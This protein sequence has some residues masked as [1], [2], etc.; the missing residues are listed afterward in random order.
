MDGGV[1]ATTGT[2]LGRYRL[3]QRIGEG[4]MGVVHLG[5][6]DDGRAFA[7]KVLRPHVAG[8]ADARQR[9]AREVSTLRRVR[10]RRIAEVVDADTDCET[11][12]VV[13]Q[14]VPGQPLDAHVREHGPVTGRSL[15]QLGDGLGEALAAIHAAGIVHRDLK[16]GNVLMLDGDPVVIDFGIAHVADDVRLTSTGLVMG[17][18]GYLSPE[19]VAGDDV[20][21]ATDWWG[22]AATMAF[23]ATGRPPFGR[24][25][26]EA[27]LDRVRRGSADLEGVPAALVPVLV[28]ALSVDPRGRPAPGVLR[29][30]VADLRA[31]AVARVDGAREE[32]VTERI[33]VPP[34]PGGVPPRPDVAHELRDRHGAE[35]S[36]SAL[37]AP[38]TRALPRAEPRRPEHVAARGVPARPAPVPHEVGQRHDGR[39]HDGP[40]ADA[41]RRPPPALDARPRPVARPVEPSPVESSWSAPRRP[42][43]SG[44]LAVGLLALCGTAA[45][46]PVGAAIIGA[47]GMVLA[48]TVD[49]SS[50]ALVR[51][52]YESGPRRG[53]RFVAAASSPWHLVVGALTT[54]PVL[55]LP[56]LVGL[57]AMFITGFVL[58]QSNPAPGRSLSLAVAAGAAVVTAWWGPGGS[59]LRRGTRSVVRG[60]SPGRVGA[61]LLV[62]LLVIVLVAA[63]VVVLRSGGAPDWSPLTGPPLGL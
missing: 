45:V 7:V 31:S 37:Q 52:R 63:V 22:W 1:A 3:V 54:V 32:P 11:P 44:T 58:Q 12:Y 40:P 48:R 38:P 15:A 21:Q 50:G 19:V 25:P 23:A 10:H 8:D 57:S 16:P 14:Y 17:T 61:Q 6:T 36:T 47:F 26:L 49:R 29:L 5:L 30:A 33:A 2:R 55:V 43:R 24:G 60:V 62:A 34:A 20:G 4:G 18:P 56:L 35:G 41:G 39:R 53:D 42:H 46:A 13:T 59:S 28:G 9:L 51:R 27:V